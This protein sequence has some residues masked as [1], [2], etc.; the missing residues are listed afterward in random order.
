MELI[1]YMRITMLISS[2]HILFSPNL[3]YSWDIWELKSE[4]PTFAEILANYGKV[5]NQIA[6]FKTE[7]AEKNSNKSKPNRKNN[8]GFNFNTQI[9]KFKQHC[10]FCQ[11]D[12]HTSDDCTTH[13]T[14][15][16]RLNVCKVKK[17]CVQCTSLNHIPG[18]Y[19]LS[20]LID[21]SEIDL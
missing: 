15:Q 13:A 19:A 6:K 1:Y 14:Y 9:R 21:I 11:I 17:L 12:G 8:S 4:Y 2:C 7:K 5:I 16:Q 10:R 3:A 18:P 20:L